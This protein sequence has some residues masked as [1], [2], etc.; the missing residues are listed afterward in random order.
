MEF[1]DPRTEE[2]TNY[3]TVECSKDS[4]DVSEAK[5]EDMVSSSH[6]KAKLG[7]RVEPDSHQEHHETEENN[8]KNGTEESL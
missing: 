4:S 2:W 8:H 1:L 5:D 6:A 3:I 7:E